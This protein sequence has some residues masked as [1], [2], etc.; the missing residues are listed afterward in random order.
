MHD[1]PADLVSVEPREL[2]QAVLCA[3]LRNHG[4]GVAWG[5]AGRGQCYSMGKP[6]RLAGYSQPAL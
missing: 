6:V 1:T 4:S 5:L 3:W 2:V